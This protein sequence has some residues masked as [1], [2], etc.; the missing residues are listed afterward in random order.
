MLL[1]LS[2]IQDALEVL[3]LARSFFELLIMKK[4]LLFI[5]FFVLTTTIMAQRNSSFLLGAKGGLVTGNTQELFSYSASI[6]MIYLYTVSNEFKLGGKSAVYNYFGSGRIFELPGGEIRETADER[7]GLLAVNALYTF[8]DEHIGVG[9]DLG[10]AFV[11]ST[12]G[13]DGMLYEPKVIYDTDRFLFSVGYQS[14]LSDDIGIDSFQ[15]G[16]A[17]KF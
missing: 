13:G 6:E 10:Y 14:I 12:D 11:I 17:Y 9:L 4:W 16:V 1:W 7:V 8:P 2:F 3:Y 15:L 5:G